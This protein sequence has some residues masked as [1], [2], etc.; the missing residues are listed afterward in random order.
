MSVAITAPMFLQIGASR[1]TAA[2]TADNRILRLLKSLRT[3]DSDLLDTLERLSSEGTR[4]PGEDDDSYLVRSV[5]DRRK[6]IECFEL[7][8]T[9]ISDD[10]V[11]SVVVFDC[12]HR[13]I[14]RC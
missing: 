14:I 12:E 1:G 6:G 11:L 5:G 10:G 8:R 7:Y 2:R 13:K 9:G 4:L 3:D